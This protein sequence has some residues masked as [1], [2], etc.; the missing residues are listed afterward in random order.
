MELH[1]NS[2]FECV[3]YIN[4]EFYER[5]DSL[6]M[7]EYDVVY[8]T[9]FPLKATL[10]P[11]TVKLSGAKNISDELASGIRLDPD[12]Y[13]LLLA[14]RYMIV[15]G[16][17]KNALPAPKSPIARLFSLVK[18]GDVTAAYSMLTEKLR[19]SIDKND[20]CSFFDGFERIAECTWEHG[21]KFYLIDKNCVA[22]LH[23]YSLKD[24]F[25]DD[26]VEPD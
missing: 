17:T 8:V 5:A 20:L 25:I 4:G 13:L 23:S 14:P 26:I 21:S 2:E 19:S 16:N 6:T 15:Y 22:K 12:H 7:S 18:T 9:V 24:G 1:I 3:Y 10:L 11:Y